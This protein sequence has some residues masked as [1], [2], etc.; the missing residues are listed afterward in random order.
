MGERPVAACSTPSDHRRTL[1]E[2]MFEDELN[3][4]Q[5]LAATHGEG[6]LLIIAGAGSGSSSTGGFVLGAD[7]NPPTQANVSRCA[8]PKLSD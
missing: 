2:R 8:S 1:L 3:P 7:E 5:R 6:P 4:E